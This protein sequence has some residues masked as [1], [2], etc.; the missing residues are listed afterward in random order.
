MK[1]FGFLIFRPWMYTMEMTIT[2]MY[3][4]YSNLS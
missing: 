1:L 3:N 4:V 2:C